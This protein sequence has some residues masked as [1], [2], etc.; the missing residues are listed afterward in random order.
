MP[1][2]AVK[3]GYGIYPIKNAGAMAGII[4]NNNAISR[5]TLYNG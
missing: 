2:A 1:L 3:P 5:A 4:Q